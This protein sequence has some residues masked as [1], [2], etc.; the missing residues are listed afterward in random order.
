LE[1]AVFAVEGFGHNFGESETVTPII[2]S[3]G[4]Q[5]KTPPFGRGRDPRRRRGY[6]LKTKSL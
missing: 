3:S 2:P 6:F 5:N 1:R 4:E